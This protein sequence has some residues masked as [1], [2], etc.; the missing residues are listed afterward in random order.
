M[1]SSTHPPII[2]DG[3]IGVNLDSFRIHLEARNRSQ[4]TITHYVGATEQ[5]THY[6]EEQGMPLFVAHVKR[7]HIEAFIRDMLRHYK[8]SSALNRYKG[9]QAFFRWLLEEGEI[10]E[11]PFARM[12]P[13]TVPDDEPPIP[14]EDAIRK[15]IA[16]CEKG[17]LFE[18]RR[19]AAIIRCLVDTGGRL[20][21]VAN[22]EGDHVDLKYRE[23]RMTVKGG[24]VRTI[25]MGAR[26]VQAL[27]RYFRARSR[28]KHAPEPWVWLGQQGRFTKSGLAQ[29][30]ETRS[31]EAGLPKLHAHQFRH[32]F[33][34]VWRLNGGGDDELMRLMGWRSRAML[35]RYARSAADE[36]A[37]EAHKRLSPGD[38]L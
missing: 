1:Q 28:H 29:M 7:E 13:P 32:F 27:D 31:K 6:L 8:P 20:S 3:D 34:H 35:N 5:L 19:D 36:R 12:H 24:R 21:E 16:V 23:L 25:P 14:H 26:S 4:A 17:R 18:D 22:L 2:T 37:R 15:L 10:T 33:A 9:V 11:T 30:L 38:R